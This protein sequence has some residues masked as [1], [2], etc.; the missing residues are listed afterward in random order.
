MALPPP[1]IWRDT[2]PAEPEPLMTMMTSETP[3]CD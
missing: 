2:P 3:S 1:L